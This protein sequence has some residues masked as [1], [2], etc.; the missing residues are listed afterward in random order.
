MG[1]VGRGRLGLG[2]ALRG[3]IVGFYLMDREVPVT[4]GQYAPTIVISY[5][6]RP[7]S[8]LARTLDLQCV[9]RSSLQ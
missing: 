8:R 2:P 4:S 9:H 6:I 3:C 5:D 1:S 7:V